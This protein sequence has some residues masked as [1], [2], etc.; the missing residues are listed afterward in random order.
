MNW[1]VPTMK[2]KTSFFNRGLSKNLL[3]RFWP[4][5]VAY[6]A[7]LLLSFCFPLPQQLEQTAHY[8]MPPSPEYL[9]L[10]NAHEQLFFDGLAA[11][12][13]VM[14]MYS[15]LYNSRSCG[16][17]NSLP[18]RRE[19]MFGTALLVG[20]VP[21]L[22]GQVLAALL[23]WLMTL[24]Y[25]VTLLWALEWL[26]ITAL[27]MLAFYGFAVFCAVLTGNLLVLPVVYL[28]LNLTAAVVEICAMGVLSGLCYGYSYNGRLQL[29]LLSPLLYVVR[30]FGVANGTYGEVIVSG[31]GVLIGYAVA[32][33]VLS[34]LAL[35]IYRRRNMEC[36]TDVVAVPIL[37]PVFQYCMAF[38]TAL[39]FTMAVCYLLPD[40]GVRGRS[41]AL[42]LL[43]LLLLGAFL[44][45][46]AA[47]M[48]IQKTVKV[49]HG[50]WKGMAV[51]WLVLLLFVGAA[52][53][54]LFGYE[55]RVPA[56]DTV[57]SVKLNRSEYT[58][59]ENVAAA[60]ALHQ[61]L[62]EHKSLHDN[63]E[64]GFGIDF[65][66]TLKNGKTLTRSYQLSYTYNEEK[67][68]PLSEDLQ[69]FQDLSNTREAIDRRMAT[70]LPVEERYV[71]D[72]YLNYSVVGESGY[73]EGGSVRL[74]PEQAVD[75]YRNA[76]LPDAAEDLVGLYYVADNLPGSLTLSNIS[77]SITLEEDPSRPHYYSSDYKYDY[78]WFGLY[79]ES[80][81][82]M[83]WL[84]ENTELG[85]QVCPEAELRRVE[86]E[87]ARVYGV[88]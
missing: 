29:S 82:S 66:Y 10:K 4:L 6:F 28:V 34:V 56:A 74:S 13:A 44:G 59:P 57:E 32:G 73:V 27:G 78:I 25:G 62:V 7:V 31:M 11:V 75:F 55:R 20:L 68:M 17:M 35:L 48:L 61:S 52:E 58:E 22:L 79:L 50:G 33:L 71:A 30:D 69:R 88:G 18:I 45:Y 80:E 51:V 85:D 36:A 86:N 60:A 84:R 67:P 39:V 15:Y 49:F 24:R 21:L 14:A 46:Y 16:M 64:G 19:T 9:L 26:G 77:V 63:A 83:Q 76:L 70:T 65:V 8:A 42:L 5:W 38:G 43:F 53:L 40:L 47:R 81:H 41:L 87:W 1:E 2:S 37:K 12:L 72:A 23:G 54:D 3:R